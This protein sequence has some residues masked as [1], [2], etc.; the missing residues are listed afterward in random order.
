MRAAFTAVGGVVGPGD[1]VG[2]SRYEATAR[3]LLDPFREARYGLSFGAGVGVTDWDGR[4]RPYLAVL[5]DLE[6]RRR[7]GWTPAVQVGLGSGWRVGLA[8]RKSR[9]TWR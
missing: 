1:W 5:S 9:G 2:E 8:L 3:F 6:L 4:W 7:P